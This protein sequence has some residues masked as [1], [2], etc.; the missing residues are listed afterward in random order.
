M[1]PPVNAL[2]YMHDTNQASSNQALSRIQ[3]K[4]QSPHELVSSTV[5]NSLWSALTVIGGYDR[6]LR[7]GAR[8]VVII[9]FVIMSWEWSYY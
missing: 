9:I 2:I 1:S 6:G 7:V 3:K 4:G 8:F 5:Y